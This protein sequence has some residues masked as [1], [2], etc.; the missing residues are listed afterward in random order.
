MSTNHLNKKEQLGDTYWVTGDGVARG[1][2]SRD[3]D[4]VGL[5]DDRLG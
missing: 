1:G 2:K 3:M 4:I 5:W